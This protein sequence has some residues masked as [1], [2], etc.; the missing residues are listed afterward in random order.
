MVV[1]EAAARRER[2]RPRGT[3]AAVI[4][5]VE[6][7]ARREPNQLSDRVVVAVVAAVRAVEAVGADRAA[8]AADTVAATANPV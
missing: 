2:N 5:E 6:R 4:A 7:A 8:E 3:V 1:V